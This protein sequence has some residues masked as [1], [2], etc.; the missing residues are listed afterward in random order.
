MINAVVGHGIKLLFRQ[1]GGLHFGRR[2]R[3]QAVRR[4][5][6]VAVSLAALVRRGPALLDLSDAI[7]S[8]LLRPADL[9]RLPERA[10][11]LDAVEVGGVGVEVD[12]DDGVLEI[13]VGP[14]EPAVAVD[15]GLE[16]H[17]KLP[18][19]DA[20]AEVGDEVEQEVAAADV[21]VHV[22]RHL[23]SDLPPF[24]HHLVS[25]QLVVPPLQLQQV[26]SRIKI[27]IFFNLETATP[28]KGRNFTTV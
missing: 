21:A 19:E 26:Q 15:E 23:S 14:E 22:Q 18:R 27:S 1:T 5:A 28:I 13:R 9:R 3:N 16:N 17:R 4:K 2:P 12:P 6:A 25:L 8:R 7:R 11:A 20:V 10:P 24:G